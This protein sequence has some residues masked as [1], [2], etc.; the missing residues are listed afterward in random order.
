MK[1]ACWEEESDVD[2]RKS[3]GNQKNGVLI[4]IAPSIAETP[5]GY[6]DMRDTIIA[7]IKE[8]RVHFAIRANS[9][10]MELYWEIGNEILRRQKNEGWGAKVI[11]RLSKDLREI[12]PDMSGFSPRNLSNMKKFAASWSDFLILQRVVAKIPWRSNIILM[13]KLPDEQ[14]RLWYAQKLLENGWSRNV[15]DT[16][17][18]SRLIDRQG[19]AVSNF[20]I[21]LLHRD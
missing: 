5:D 13:D 8:S 4:P 1:G 3:M 10:M 18:A 2:D 6:I 9:G 19:K 7:K 20:E 16:M 15:L 14:T 12:F 17:I 11:D 21:A